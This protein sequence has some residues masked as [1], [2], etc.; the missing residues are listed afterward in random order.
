M[1]SE[2]GSPF[3]ILRQARRISE[4]F[5]AFCLQKKNL[6][7]FREVFPAE[8]TPLRRWVTAALGKLIWRGLNERRRRI[9]RV[10][11]QGDHVA[12]TTELAAFGGI[13]APQ[14]QRLQNGASIAAEALALGQNAAQLG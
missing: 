11:C 3:R 10:A 9:G 1:E 6:F 7:L 4:V 2:G 5:T 14:G 12:G 8:C 13:E